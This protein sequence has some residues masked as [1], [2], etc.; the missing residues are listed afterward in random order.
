MLKQLGWGLFFLSTITTAVYA[1]TVDI[2]HNTDCGISQQREITPSSV[3]CAEPEIP[4]PQSDD[5]DFY[6]QKIS[7]VSLEEWYDNDVFSSC[8]QGSREACRELQQERNR[9]SDSTPTPN[10]VITFDENFDT[11]LE[12]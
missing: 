5:D 7:N 3:F 6:T 4:N 1:E 11:Q 12:Y 2:E 10:S 8:Y 9:V